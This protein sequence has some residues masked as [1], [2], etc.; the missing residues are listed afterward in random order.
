M[1]LPAGSTRSAIEARPPRSPVDSGL[2]DGGK[3]GM[4]S[5]QS[6]G[7]SVRGVAGEEPILWIHE[8]A[9]GL[10]IR[11]APLTMLASVGEW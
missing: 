7:L 8:V 2:P 4:H 10:T 3:L 6:D 11:Q 5:C 1:L 9:P